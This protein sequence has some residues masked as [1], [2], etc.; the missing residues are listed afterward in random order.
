MERL[1]F[2]VRLW[3]NIGAVSNARDELIL[4]HDRAVTAR[5]LARRVEQREAAVHSPAP[6]LVGQAA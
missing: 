3:G 1:L 5:V 4:A 6:D 2:L